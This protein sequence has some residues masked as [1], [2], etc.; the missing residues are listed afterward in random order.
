MSLKSERQEN[1]IKKYFPPF[2][3]FRVKNITLF[4]Y[5]KGLKKEQNQLI[6]LGPKIFLNRFTTGF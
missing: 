4:P 2:Q 3:Y 5:V 6:V 1:S